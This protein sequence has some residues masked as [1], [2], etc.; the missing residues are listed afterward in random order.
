MEKPLF[1]IIIPTL[2]E[3]KYLPTLLSCIQKQTEK[4]FEVIVVDGKSNDKTIEKTKEFIPAI[5]NLQIL[6][7]EKRNVSFQRNLGAEKA[8]GS[9]LV[10]FDADIQIPRGFFHQLKQ[11][12][13][14]KKSVFL[15]TWVIPDSLLEKDNIATAV[16]NIYSEAAKAMDRPFAGGYCLIIQRDLFFHIGGFDPNIKIGEDHAF[17]IKCNDAGIKLTILKEPRVILSMRRMRRY[18]Y[19]TMASRYIRASA[20]GLL[21]QPIKE[22][23]FEYPMGGEHYIEEGRKQPVSKF[24]AWLLERTK[25]VLED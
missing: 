25:K 1:S 14:K 19:F 7:S 5:E 20:L 11:A 17:T 12:I 24:E 10:F 2:N 13:I 22:A 15:T 3:E 6:T 4:E 9:Y 18:G 16:T 23:I 21:R 8:L